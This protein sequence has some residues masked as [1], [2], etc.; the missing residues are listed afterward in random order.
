M[1]NQGGTQMD[2]GYAGSA[3]PN[4]LLAPRRTTAPQNMPE[5]PLPP[6]NG[7][8]INIQPGLKGYVVHVGCQFV[9]FETR[10]RLLAEL[11]R[12]LENP[13]GVENEY[14]QEKK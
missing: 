7:R 9:A 3:V 6:T 12:Y 2:V 5:I 8:A 11:A 4:E 1:N 13:A 10:E 14:L